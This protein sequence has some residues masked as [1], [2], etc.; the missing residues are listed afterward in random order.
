MLYF[1]VSVVLKMSVYSN[2]FTFV[3]DCMDVFSL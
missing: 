2:I 1:C 3:V